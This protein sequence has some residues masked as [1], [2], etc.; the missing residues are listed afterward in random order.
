MSNCR[1]LLPT[2]YVVREEVIFSLCVSVHTLVGGGYLPSKVWT[3]G[4]VP[5]FPGL[6]LEGGGYLPSQVWM[7]DTYLPKSGQGG[8]PAFPGRGGGYLPFQ[9]WMGGYLP[10]RYPPRARYPPTRVGTY[11]HQSLVPPMGVPTPH[12][13]LVPP[14]VGTC[15]PRQGKGGYPLPWQGVPTFP[16]LGTPPGGVG[17]PHLPSVGTPCLG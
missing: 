14:R 13:G 7:G 5:T 3:G 10:G 4:G 11:L 6:G 12:Q 9:V 15:L 2:A 8:I 16:G 17:T 1:L